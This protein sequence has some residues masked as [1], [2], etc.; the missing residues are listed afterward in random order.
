MT[1]NNLPALS[2]VIP[3][4]NLGEVP[5]NMSESSGA[6]KNPNRFKCHE[7]DSE[8]HLRNN[9]PVK[10]KRLA[11]LRTER[12]ETVVVQV[13]VTGMVQMQIPTGSSLP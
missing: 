4:A 13:T 2:T 10:K 9:C 5:Q 1:I 6:R 7:C 3:Q 8:Y 11:E 12:R